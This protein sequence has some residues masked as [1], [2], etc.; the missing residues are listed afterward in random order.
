MSNDDNRSFSERTGLVAQMGGMRDTKVMRKIWAA[1]YS[2]LSF[3]DV[4]KVLREVFL[5]SPSKLDKW[6]GGYRLQ[7]ERMC[8]FPNSQ[9]QLLGKYLPDA[10]NTLERAWLKANEMGG[11]YTFYDMC[12]FLIAE[13][14]RGGHISDAILDMLDKTPNADCR[15]V[16]G[17]F[18]IVRSP[19]EGETI[20]TALSGHFV[21]ART[22]IKK[23]VTLFSNREHPD[24]ANTVKESVSAVESIIKELTEKDIKSGLRQL[25][26]DGILPKDITVKQDGKPQKVN[27][28]VDALEKHWDFANKTSRHGLKSGES[29]PDEDAAY[30]ILVICAAVVNY[31]AARKDKSS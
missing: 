14:L 12:E 30:L 3:E 28:F 24:Y 5:L 4:I 9:R 11:W 19:E 22:H 26:K 21:E 27:P 17:K 29:P 7:H 18:I 25:V 23:A 31:I 20:E 15:L 1:I 6:Y 13:S 16:K 10:Y 2:I 8:N